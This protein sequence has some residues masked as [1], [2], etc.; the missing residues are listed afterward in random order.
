LQEATKNVLYI[1]DQN[2]EF[3]LLVDASDHKVAG[4]LTQFSDEGV[5]R[6]IAFFSWKLNK[7]QQGWSTVEQEAY[8]A[9][10][11][12]QRVKQWVIAFL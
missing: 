10:R 8:A 3:N 11:A 9:L 7:T 5:E 4:V 1:I 12:L 6:P 2:R